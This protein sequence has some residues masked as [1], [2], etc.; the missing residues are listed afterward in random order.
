M[1]LI[2][3]QADHSERARRWR[4]SVTTAARRLSAITAAGALLGLVVGGVGGRLAMFALAQ[5]NPGAAGMSSDDGFTI[6]QFTAL[7]SLNLLFAGTVLGALG[8]AVYT[9][10]R[11]LLIGPQ[12]FRVL[13]ISVGPAVVVGE[14]LVH[15]DGVDFAL[16]PAWLAIGMFVLIPGLYAGLLCVVAERWLAPD[17]LFAR[18]PLPLALA[19]LLTLAPLAPVLV[20][21]ALGW[22]AVEATRRRFGAV[23]AATPAA[24]AGRAALAAIFCVALARLVEE[25]R[26]LT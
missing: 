21:L 8:A 9:G 10:L 26:L 18:G 5:L 19:P 4:D 24:W 11:P 1:T 2:A 3:A 15:V 17:R 16:D 25:T 13:S 14:Q 7:G 20:L 23:P 22:L 6:G 12:W